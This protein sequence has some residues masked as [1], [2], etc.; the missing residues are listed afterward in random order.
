MNIYTLNVG[1]GQFVVVTGDT[2]AVII[3]SH[4]PLDASQPVVNVK[5][6]LAKALEGKNLVG[7][8]ATGFDADHFNEV[9]LK[10]IL[11]KYRPKWFM[12]PK[13]FK[14][15]D[16]ADKCFKVIS[17]YRLTNDLSKIS[18]LLDDASKRFYTKLSVDLQFELFSPHPADM[19]SSNNCSLV[20]KV[21]E[22]STSATYLVTGD[23]ENAR[24]DSIVRYFGGSVEAHVLAAPHH[25]SGN[26]ITERALAC[27]RPHTTLISAG[28][29]NQY[30]HP[31]RDTVKLMERFSKECY[32]TNYGGG[33]SLRTVV[34]LCGTKTYKFVP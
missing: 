32:S 3:D 23:T 8:I 11:N 13:Y 18:V 25:G 28:V 21:R 27:I 10:I 29:D 14:G 24:W 20:C 30:G 31:D 2:D 34:S 1:Q 4:V 15:T 16:E 9:G 6:A 17:D 22:Q 26:G 12:Y 5:R 7:F 19:D 33:Q